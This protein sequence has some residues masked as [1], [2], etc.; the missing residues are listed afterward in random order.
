[1]L[2]LAPRPR[3]DPAFAC[4]ATWNGERIAGLAV[5]CSDGRWGEAFD[6]FCQEHLRMP[7]FDRWA[8]PGGP[9][10]LVPSEHNADYCRA[11]WEQLDFL[12]RLHA[13]RRI[14]LITH[15]GCAAYGARLGQDPEGCLPTQLADLHTAGEALREWFSAVRVETY[16]A[17]REGSRISFYT[18]DDMTSGHYLL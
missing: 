11:T 15:H 18:A 5:Y 16:L 12:A 7:R 2:T 14:I 6:E 13:L 9:M 4:R 8:V 3:L 10:A 17:M 1:M